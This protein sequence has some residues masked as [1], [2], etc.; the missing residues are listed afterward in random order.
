MGIIEFFNL[1]LLFK[2]SFS[3]EKISKKYTCEILSQCVPTRRNNQED[4]VEKQFEEAFH[5]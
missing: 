1:I 2:K 5:S 4:K 3:F